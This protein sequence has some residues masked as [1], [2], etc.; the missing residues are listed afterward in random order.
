MRLLTYV[1]LLPVVVVVALAV[2]APAVAEPPTVERSSSTFG[3]FVDE[4]TCA[5]PFSV[6]VERTRTTIYYENG[7][8]KRH[9]EL[10]VT[11]T[12]NGK[13][14]VQRNA[15]NVFIDA[16]SPGLWVITGVFEKAQLHGRTLWLE[17]GR[18][19]Y[20]VEAD[21]VN[22]PNP[23]PLAEPSDVCQLLGP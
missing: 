23:G 16:D 13:S 19:V 21:Q 9:T 6:T 20:D 18:L 5:F 14:V 11:A 8:V 12:A 22:D 15:F 10:I 1:L 17:S 4:E 3:P 7:D 2:A